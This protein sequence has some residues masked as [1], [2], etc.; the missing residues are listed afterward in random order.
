MLVN[1]SYKHKRNDRDFIMRH[2]QQ[3]L[4]IYCRKTLPTV[5]LFCAL[6]CDICPVS[7]YRFHNAHSTLST[8]VCVLF[9]ANI[10]PVYGEL[11]N[12]DGIASWIVN[13]CKADPFSKLLLNYLWPCLGTKTRNIYSTWL[14]L[15]HE[16]FLMHS[17]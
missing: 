7:V 8:F 5:A 17:N 6:R 1:K 16:W 4:D 14:D 2:I 9:Y 11:S 12:V 3:P 15:I 13:K 10:W